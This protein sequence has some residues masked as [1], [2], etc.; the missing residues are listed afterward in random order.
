MS[1]RTADA[2][3]AGL[4]VVGSGPSALH[5]AQGALER[6]RTVTML[7]VGFERRPPV[8]PEASFEDLK[9]ELDDPVEYFLGQRFQSVL[10]PGAAGEY[11]G[12]P[13]TKDFVFEG[14][15]G[16]DVAARG[17][18]PLFSYARGGLAEAWTGAA[19]PFTD[20]ELIDF[21]FGYAELG[22]Y[23]DRVA[24][25]IGVCGAEDD[26]APFVPV[27]AN[28]LPPLELDAHARVLA[29]RYERQR[30]WLNERLGCYLGRSRSATLSSARDGRPAC[31]HLG[32]CLWGCPT[33]SLYTPHV[34]L[35][36]LLGRPG[37]HYVPGRHVRWFELG[38]DRRATA[39][40]SQRLDTRELER[41]PVEAL[42]L[43][44]G[45]LSSCRVF[46]ESLWRATGELARLEGLMDNRQ[47]LV[48]FVSLSRLGANW[49]PESFQYHQLALGFAAADPKEYVHGLVT[50]LKTALI[51]PIVQNVPLDLRTALHVFRNVHAALGLVNVNLSDGR[52]PGNAVTLEPRG[53]GEAPRLVVH[54]EPSPGEPRALADALR[55]TRRALRRLGCVVPPGMTHVRPMGA[56]VHYAGLLPM[57]RSEGPRTTTPDGRS[58]DVPNVWFVDGTTFP[59]LPAKNLTFTLMA[60]AARIA[61]RME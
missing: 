35:E 5:F 54:Y 50:T 48:P 15:P 14:L 3:G 10:F 29:D 57:T 44:A 21:P 25:R 34:T 33:D 52:R 12:F 16:S 53:E 45:T 43:G 28:L 59:F 49:E 1:E 39:V 24:E 13:P 61:D 60:N 51:H 55:R 22:P 9:R 30:R 19:L 37:F 32:R 11:Y 8:R 46:L 58:R 7:D 4:V 41:M 40:V 31:S 56:S 6:G 27:H 38:P 18:A 20:A 42:V 2:P 26:L 36:R 23:Y 17:F 47:A